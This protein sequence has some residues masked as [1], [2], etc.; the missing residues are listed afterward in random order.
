MDVGDLQ[1]EHFADR[2]GEPFDTTLDDGTR[3]TLELIA[4]RE[5]PEERPDHAHFAEWKGPLDRPLEQRIYEL[6]HAELG[7]LPIFLVPVN[8]VDDG[9][10]YEAVFTRVDD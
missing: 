5:P 9:F 7:T 4:A 10:V 1:H 6:E 2:I 3:V 8:Q